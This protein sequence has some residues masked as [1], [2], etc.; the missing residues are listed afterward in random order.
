MKR[1]V[2]DRY[3]KYKGTTKD[4]VTSKLY[5]EICNKYQKFLMDKVLDGKEV[6]FPARMGSLQVIGKK[7]KVTVDGEGNISGLAPDWVATKQLWERDPEARKQRK[8]LFHLNRQSDG[9]R[10]RF[11]WSKSRVLVTNKVLYSLRIARA[12]KREVS[13]R[14]LNG[15][16]YK[17]IL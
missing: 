14:I 13:E 7:E 16:N 6:C 3:K 15:T 2:G 5:R 17:T 12:N 10:Y 11:F 9:Y 8:R 1:G 4:P